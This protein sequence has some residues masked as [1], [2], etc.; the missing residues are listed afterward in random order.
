VSLALSGGAGTL[1]GLI[2]VH[3]T[4]TSSLQRRDSWPCQGFYAG[5]GSPRK[6][7]CIYA[8]VARVFVTLSR[9]VPG[10]AVE[11]LSFRGE[12]RKTFFGSTARL[13]ALQ[14]S[15]GLLAL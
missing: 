13:V 9:P 6:V 1:T 4:P 8:P 7:R 12:V 2:R 5:P 10:A 3:T 15:C 14:S 11:R